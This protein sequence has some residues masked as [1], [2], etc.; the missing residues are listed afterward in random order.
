[1]ATR[2]VGDGDGRACVVRLVGVPDRF[3][4][5]GESSDWLARL[6]LDAKGIASR[7]ARELRALRTQDA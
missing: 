6:Q 3:I 1:L 4:P 5:H 7:A 2:E